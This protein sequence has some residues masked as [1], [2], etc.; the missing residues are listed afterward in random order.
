MGNEVKQRWLEQAL[1]QL[2]DIAGIT[3][4]Q[5]NPDSKTKA[6]P[7][8]ITLHSK[9]ASQ[10]YVVQHKSLSN[11]NQHAIIEQLKQASQTQ[12]LEPL[13]VT[14]YVSSANAEA[15]IK[16]GINYIDSAG[17]M[18]LENKAFYLHVE[19]KKPAKQ[20]SPKDAFSYTGL[21]LIYALLAYPELRQKTYRDIQRASHLGLGS[22]SRIISSLIEQTYLMKTKDGRLYLAESQK[23]IERWELGY[24]EILRPKLEPSSWKLTSLNKKEILKILKTQEGVVIGGEEVAARLSSY[25]KPQTL[26][27]H[28]LAETQKD[29]RIKLRLLPEK[30]KPEL[31]LLSPII[32]YDLSSANRKLASAIRARAELLAYGGDRL[33]ETAGILLNET[34]LPELNDAN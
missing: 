2:N 32:P 21:K 13:L 6:S 8:V 23:L 28:A 9:S 11:A 33:L 26:T 18:H 15:L 10:S 29:L 7:P 19:G 25:L 30:N 5:E 17:N 31:Y 12:R 1:T 34:I 4:I 3:S 14:T 16:Q 20:L 22:I 27:L 24:L